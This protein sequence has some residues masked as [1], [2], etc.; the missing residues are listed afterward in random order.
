MFC[1]VLWQSEK[2][3]IPEFV[4][5]ENSYH[6]RNPGLLISNIAGD[7]IAN[8][9][10]LSIDILAILYNFSIEVS[11]SLAK[12]TLFDI[13]TSLIFIMLKRH[14]NVTKINLKTVKNL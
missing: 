3:S 5:C 13:D 14:K 7:T 8:T 4:A 11:V 9:F 12:F 1:R 2:Y 6:V 10:R